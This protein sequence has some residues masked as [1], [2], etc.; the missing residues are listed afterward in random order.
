MYVIEVITRNNDNNNN[1]HTHKKINKKIN[2][3]YSFSS[4]PLFFPDYN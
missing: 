2:F 4:P 1:K 3:H